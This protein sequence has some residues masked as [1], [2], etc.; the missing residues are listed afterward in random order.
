MWE[1]LTA[2]LAFWLRMEHR[3]TRLEE[4]VKADRKRIER[5]EAAAGMKPHEAT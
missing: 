1:V 3:L 4:R 5:L 2:V